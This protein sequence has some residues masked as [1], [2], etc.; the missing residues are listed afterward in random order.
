MIASES[1]FFFIRP[2]AWHWESRRGIKEAGVDRPDPCTVILPE[3]S[4]Y[5]LLR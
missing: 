2:P 1:L 3:W 4:A 5:Q